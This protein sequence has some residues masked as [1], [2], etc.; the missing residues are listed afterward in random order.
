MEKSNLENPFGRSKCFIKG[1]G[2]GLMDCRLFFLVNRRSVV[3]LFVCCFPYEARLPFRGG[4]DGQIWA[5]QGGA[6][7]GEGDF[8]LVREMLVCS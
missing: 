4:A 1:D 7:R 6:G 2:G 8:T 3:C 5:G